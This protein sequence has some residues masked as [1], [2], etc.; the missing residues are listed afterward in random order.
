MFSR[1]SCCSIFPS[2]S[3]HSALPPAWLFCTF[4]AVSAGVDKAKDLGAGSDGD[5]HVSSKLSSYLS[6][7][8]NRLLV[9][10]FFFLLD[11]CR[12]DVEQ[13]TNCSISEH[14]M[15]IVYLQCTKSQ[16]AY[17]IFSLWSGA[18]NCE[19]LHLVIPM[20]ASMRHV[21]TLVYDQSNLLN[22]S[23]CLLFVSYLV[24]MSNCL[25]FCSLTDIKRLLN[26]E[27]MVRCAYSFAFKEFQVHHFFLVALML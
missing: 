14:R 11:S 10:H 12:C 18:L 3:R 19:S 23:N 9:K 7:W 8:K 2:S 1:D 27:F 21:S 6:I 24:Y 13:C 16:I 25:L 5:R 17:F 26:S 15:I 20:A 4:A 22:M